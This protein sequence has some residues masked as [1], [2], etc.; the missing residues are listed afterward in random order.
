MIFVFFQGTKAG[1]KFSIHAPDEIPL[2][3]DRFFRINSLSAAFVT[4]SPEVYKASENLRS[5]NPYKRN[6]FFTDERPLRFFHQYNQINCAVEC[7]ANYTLA[8]CGCVKFSMPRLFDTAICDASHIECY[9]DSFIQLYELAIRASLTGKSFKT[10]H[11][12]PS[13]TSVEY[14]VGLSQVPINNFPYNLN[15]TRDEY[16]FSRRNL[17]F[18][19]NILFQLSVWIMP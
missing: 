6:C 8:K 10:C 4:V 17:G 3:H 16:L 1:F 18:Q 11:C 13:C 5:I 12:L 9:R 14:R 2:T 19:F 7:I 15:F